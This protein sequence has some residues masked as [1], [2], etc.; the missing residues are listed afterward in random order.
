MQGTK[1]VN[2]NQRNLIRKVI[3]METTKEQ[4][5]Q[6]KEKHNHDHDHNH[7]KMPIILY[8]IGLALAIVALFLSGEYQLIKNIMFSLATISA[9][10]HV[11]VLEGLGNN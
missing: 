10:Y 6:E 7:G 3:E 8:F 9:G 11:I 1:K 2:K 5:S 4:H